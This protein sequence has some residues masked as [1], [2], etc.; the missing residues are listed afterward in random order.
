MFGAILY[1]KGFMKLKDLPI[2][3]K[4]YEKIEN[5]GA[6]FL[7][8]A[9][10]L[11]VIIKNGTKDKTA[12]EIAQELLLLDY[13]NQG[14]S[15]LKDISLEDLANIKGLGRVKSIQ[16][17]ALVEFAIRFSKPSSIKK[18]VITSPEI[19]ASILMNELK[20][21]TQEFIKTLIL[22]TQNELMRI[23]TITK[24]SSNSSYVE[25][26]DIFKDAIKSN[27]SK[28]I[29]VHN[30]P[31]GQVDPSEAD[32]ALTERVKIAGELL[33]IELVD[34]IIIGNGV[35]TSLKRKNLMWNTQ[36]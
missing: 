23:V 6:K 4:P 31:S 27:A 8:N 3:E 24:G 9:E 34:H 16:I 17:K 30:H 19:V 20:D 28:I 10:L 15:F 1:R 5:Y 36:K 2:T 26:K 11:A 14:L 12:V 13:Q 35:F 21:E 7:S 32:I 25:I 29:L 18:N 22:N 33:S